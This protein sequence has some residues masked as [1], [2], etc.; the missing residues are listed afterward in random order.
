MSD[1]KSE[2]CV[3]VVDDDDGMRASLLRLL[4]S[5]GL[6]AKGFVSARAFLDGWTPADSGCLMADVWMPEMTGMDLHAELIRRGGLIP[7]ILMSARA[8]VPDV[9]RAMTRGAIDF[10]E[11]PFRDQDL[12]SLVKRAMDVDLRREWESGR[13]AQI[14]ARLSTLT[15]REREV[16]NL[17]VKGVSTKE[18]A[19][20]LKMSPKTADVHRFRTLE[21]MQV[22]SLVELAQLMFEYESLRS[23]LPS[24]S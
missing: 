20:Q 8:R 1:A 19:S 23:R 14:E 6:K 21:K 3:Y 16:M 18:A 11:K 5:E 9:V 13:R 24:P 17:L 4:K 7:V 22:E 15:A 12:I 10:L 2:P